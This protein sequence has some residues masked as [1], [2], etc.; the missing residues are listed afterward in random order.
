MDDQ[1]PKVREL[2]QRNDADCHGT[3]VQPVERAD[4]WA[5]ADGPV[6]A[7]RRLVAQARRL[8]STREKKACGAPA[9]LVDV[10][11]APQR[12]PRRAGTR[13]RGGRMKIR[14]LVVDDFPLVREGLTASLE[15]DPDIE[16]VGEAADGESG[17]QLAAELQPDV[18]LTDM[19][20]PGLG[21]PVLL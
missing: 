20:M 2:V 17:L 9:R 7:F 4:A 3:E 12:R 21:G 11:P 1:H 6:A 13:R 8:A 18:I 16:V 15:V 19:R 5:N 10:A 14:V